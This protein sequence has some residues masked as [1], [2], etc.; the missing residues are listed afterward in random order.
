MERSWKASYIVRLNLSF[1]ESQELDI[2][3]EEALKY[4]LYSR[5]V[6]MVQGKVKNRNRHLLAFI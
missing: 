6:D 2:F 4:S 3:L 1:Y 5:E